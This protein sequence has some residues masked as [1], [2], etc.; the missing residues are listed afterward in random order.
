MLLVALPLRHPGDPSCLQPVHADVE[1]AVYVRGEG[2]ARAVGRPAGVPGTDRTTGIG[3]GDRIASLRRHNKGP[4]VLT[5]RLGDTLI[6]ATVKQ[7]VS[8]S[9]GMK[10]AFMLLAVLGLASLWAAVFADMGM[11]LIVTL[12]GMRP[13]RME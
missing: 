4:I 12:N 11:S 3:D 5:V 1:K 6:L 13:V 10:L 7:N 8:L 9:F 2:D